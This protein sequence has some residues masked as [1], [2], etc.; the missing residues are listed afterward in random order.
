[1]KTV[2]IPSWALLQCVCHC[3]VSDTPTMGEI[4]RWQPGGECQLAPSRVL[5]LRIGMSM[6]CGPKWGVGTD[7]RTGRPPDRGVNSSSTCP[8]R[9]RTFGWV[10]CRIGHSNRDGLSGGADPRGWRDTG[11]SASGGEMRTT[12]SDFDHKSAEKTPFRAMRVKSAPDGR[13]GWCESV[14]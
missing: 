1:M 5:V 14:R 12:R 4:L 10:T 11:W 8:S 7:A 3:V 2:L 13:E 9:I 6:R